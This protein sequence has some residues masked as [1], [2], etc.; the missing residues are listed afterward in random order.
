MDMSQ[1]L[2]TGFKQQL[3]LLG[4][5]DARLLTRDLG[6]LWVILGNAALMVG[7][8]RFTPGVHS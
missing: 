3:G 4:A 7:L 8:C 2:L 5:R 1:A 6:I